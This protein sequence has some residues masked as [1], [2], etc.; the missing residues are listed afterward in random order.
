MKITLVLVLPFLAMLGCG[1]RAKPLAPDSDITVK[2]IREDAPKF[3]REYNVRLNGSVSMT[4]TIYNFLGITYNGELNQT[5]GKWVFFD[6][7]N[8]A[9]KIIDRNLL[10]LV[11]KKCREIIAADKDFRSNKPS[12]FTDED[13]TVWEIKRN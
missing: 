13:G 3:R 6:P 5:F 10:P 12:E 4:V 1:P 11:Q 9:D 2:S 8:P 7:E